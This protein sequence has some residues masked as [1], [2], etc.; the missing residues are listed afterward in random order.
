MYIKLPSTYPYNPTRLRVENP[1]ISFPEQMPDER[2]AEWGVFPVIPQTRP[3][4]PYTKVLEEITPIQIN[5]NWTQQWLLRDYTN[6]EVETLANTIR[7]ERNRLLQESDWTQVG[8][9][10]VDKTIWATYRQELRDTT[11]QTEFPFNVTWP[12]KPE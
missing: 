3:E 9:T 12:T 5:N 6:Q 8:D 1:N 2:L 4:V 11:L 7:D 10:P